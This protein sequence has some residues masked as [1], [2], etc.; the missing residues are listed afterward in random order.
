MKKRL[1]V[2]LV[3]LAAA[4]TH[5]APVIVA[6]P[7][8]AI[9]RPTHNVIPAP[10]FIALSDSLRFIADSTTSVT[11]YDD[12][13]VSLEAIAQNLAEMV[14]SHVNRLP[15][16]MRVR[17]GGFVL[18]TDSS[19]ANFGAEGYAIGI[20]P[21]TVVLTAK[22][23]A[24]IFYG[25]QTI[26]QL[27][28]YSVEHPAAVGR[29]LWLP[30]GNIVDNPRFEWRGMMLDVSRHFLPPADIKRFIDAMA[31][32]KMNRL[33]LH[34]ADDQG[35][36]IEIKSRPNLA[37]I[38]GSTKVGGGSGGYF[39][40]ADYKDLVAYALS[41]YITIIPEID[42]PAH[43]NA[44]Q[45]AIPELNCNNQPT[46]PYM[47][48]NV[49]FSA[50]CVD[51]P[52]VYS[53]I[54]DVVREISAMT[55]GPYFHIGGDEVKKLTHPQY[56]AFVERVQGIVNANGKRMI[57]WGEISR[58]NLQP[59]TI[60][61]SWIRDSSVLQVARGGKVIL[62]Q[63]KKAYLDMKYDTATVLGLN[64]AGYI[65]VKASYD[66]E[67]AELLPNISEP[68][69]LGVEGPLWS[70]TLVKRE[71]YEFMAFPRAIA[72]AEVAWSSRSAHNWDD[73]RQRLGAQAGRLAAIGINFYRAP[74][75]PWVER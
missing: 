34:L 28:P 73:F 13:S 71:D 43:I 1:L 45:S 4:C 18:Q 25:V 67:P 61:Q 70:E 3:A 37:L 35:W 50:L 10:S 6:P 27:L 22:T 46:N 36:R 52:A 14:G 51:S 41:R 47:G 38:G 66:W 33:H 32:Y 63:S 2:S 24:G 54:E 23:D 15:P 55:P 44:A 60:V 42:M 17:V 40:Q 65:S 9:A 48:I 57:G 12:A 7:A 11:I 5:T 19:R 16:G 64:W 31:L 72:L 56:V 75:V 26:R 69:I 29:K 53:F 58:A 59:S 49:G 39:T 20:Y 62:S 74:D 21:Q 8:P 68:S 30:T